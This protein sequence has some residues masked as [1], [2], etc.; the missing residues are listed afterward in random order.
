MN[1]VPAARHRL[2]S[3]RFQVIVIGGGIAGVAIA[4]ECARAGRRTLLIEQQDFASGTTSRSTRIVH[5]GLRHLENGDLRLVGE[6]LREQE[7]RLREYPYLVNPQEFLVPL[8]RPSRNSALA[9]RLGIWLYRRMGGKTISSLSARS[10]RNKLE[11]LLDHSSRWAVFSYEDARCEFPERLVAEWL[12]EACEAGA[13]ARNHTQ[14]PGRRHS[15]RAGAGVLI[16]DGLNGREERVESTWVINATGPW[17]DRICQRSQVK[18]GKPLV[19]GVRGSHLV[20]PRFS[21]FPDAAVC[22]SDSDARA[23]SVVPW[24]DQV[25]VGTTAEIDGGD[26]A[27]A[28]PAGEEMD[29]LLRWLQRLFPKL[30]ISNQDIRYA[31]SGVRPLPA[32]A[33]RSPGSSSAVPMVHDHSEDGASNLISVIGGTLS[34]AARLA[35]QCALRMGIRRAASPPMALLPTANFDPLLE[36]CVVEIA[37]T[38]GI[39]ERAARGIIEWHGRRAMALAQLAASDARMR[40]PLS[41]HSHHVVAEAVEA[42][43]REHAVTLGDVLLRRVPVA[44]AACCSQECGREA[45][46]RIRAV[47]GWTEKQAGSELDAFEMERA[48]FLGRPARGGHVGQAAAD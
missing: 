10:E 34:T 7:R 14:A 48:A 16:R 41:S 3:E 1:L 40:A 38:A 20:L 8:G 43:T 46:A 42:F 2:D 13:V 18:S 31:C 28:Q 27:K 35:R 24:N 47:V 4:R 26:P 36:G 21:G 44:F 6:P 32:G 39:G 29:Y 22:S 17:V 37:N 12:L 11:R 5:G 25:L 45:M 15:P 9:V 30:A 23:L 33:N 19:A